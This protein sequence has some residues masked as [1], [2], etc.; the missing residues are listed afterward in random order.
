MEPSLMSFMI[1]YKKN[2][3]RSHARQIQVKQAQ[4]GGCMSESG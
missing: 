3:E 2:L 1:R 4:R